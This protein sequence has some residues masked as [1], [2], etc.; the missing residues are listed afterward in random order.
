MTARH[1]LGKDKAV[2]S[3]VKQCQGVETP[4]QDDTDRN[5]MRQCCRDAAAR[6][7]NTAQMHNR[8]RS[9]V[10]GLTVQSVLL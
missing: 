3:S 6:T 5:S 9:P 8:S 2:S 4:F 1:D 10:T 7:V